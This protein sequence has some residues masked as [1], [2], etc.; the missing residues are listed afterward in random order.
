[1]M[2]DITLNS[3]GERML[4]EMAAGLDADRRETVA[5]ANAGFALHF[6]HFDSLYADA[7]AHLDAAKAIGNR[8]DNSG[9][10]IWLS[11]DF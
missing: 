5:E 2:H 1:M 10:P 8:Y 4:I 6:A 9:V 3:R 11:P 7:R